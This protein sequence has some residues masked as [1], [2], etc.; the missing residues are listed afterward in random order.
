MQGRSGC[1][2]GY[3][4]AVVVTLQSWSTAAGQVAGR[5]RRLGGCMSALATTDAA[6][7]DAAPPISCFALQLENMAR[8]YVKHENVI[9]LAVTPANADL[10]TSDALRLAREVDPTGE[11]TV[12]EQQGRAAGERGV[13]GG[14]GGAQGEQR[15]GGSLGES[16]SLPARAVVLL[17]HSAAPHPSNSCAPPGVLTKLDIMDPGTNCRDV[18]EGMTYQLRNGWIGVVNR[19]QADINSR[20]GG[21]WGGGPGGLGGGCSRACCGVQPHSMPTLTP[22]AHACRRR[23]SAC[24]PLQMSMQDARAKEMGFF[25]KSDYAGQCA[26]PRQATCVGAHG[27]VCDYCAALATLCSSQRGS[28]SP[29]PLVQA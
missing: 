28:P 8:D 26:Q 21:G 7:P 24:L 16:S 9:I 5:S 19:G 2:A 18:L 23:S 4:F 17:H 14:G 11:R 15:G 22:P 12:G 29:P 27:L 10:A 20:V 1:A 25:N 6:P 13:P 3:I